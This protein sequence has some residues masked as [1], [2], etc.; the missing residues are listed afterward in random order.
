MSKYGVPTSAVTTASRLG[1]RKVRVRIIEKSED[2]GLE[3]VAEQTID[4]YHVMNNDVAAVKHNDN[5]DA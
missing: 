4:Q 3:D 5:D 1:K 2:S